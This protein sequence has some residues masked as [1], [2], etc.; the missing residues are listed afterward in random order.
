MI[1]RACVRAAKRGDAAAIKEIGN[2]LDGMPHQSIDLEAVL[3]AAPL[4]QE[5]P[6]PP[7][8]DLNVVRL[9]TNGRAED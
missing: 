4:I 2:R 7:M 1:A 6:D 5:I 9:V 3:T 8:I